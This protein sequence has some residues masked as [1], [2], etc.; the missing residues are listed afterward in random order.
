LDSQR[1]RIVFFILA[2]LGIILTILMQFVPAPLAGFGILIAS[3]ALL[4]AVLSFAVKDY[5]YL[6][7]PVLHMKGRSLVLDANEPFYLAANGKAIVIRAGNT[8]Y[9]TSF[10]KIPIY[11]SS[12]EMSDEEKFNFA[13]IFSRAISISTVPMRLS[14]QLHMVNKDEYLQVITDRLSEVEDRYN[15][16]LADKNATKEAVDRVKGEVNMWHN[17]LDGI[18]KSNS[19]AQIAYVTVTSSGGSEDEAVNLASMN[20]EQLSAGLSTSLGVPTSVVNGQDIL[21][22][23][24]PE[25]LIPASAINEFAKAEKNMI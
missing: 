9:A 24:E 18:T 7:D 12:T 1:E 2:G 25:F 16:V 5:S 21:L 20:A 17:L 23:V 13:T 22:F 4:L 3:A 15:S 10:I 14:S 6:I 8:T 19:Q 11:R